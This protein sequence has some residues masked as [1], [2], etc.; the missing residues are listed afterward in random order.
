M[1][2]II[3]LIIA[4]AVA[5]ANMGSAAMAAGIIAEQPAGIIEDAPELLEVIDETGT[6]DT[7]QEILDTAA[8][9]AAPGDKIVVVGNVHDV[10]EHRT[11]SGC[12]YVVRDVGTVLNAD[13]DGR[14]DGYPEGHDYISYRGTGFEPGDRVITYT[15]MNPETD[16]CDD[17]LGRWDYLVG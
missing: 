8:G 3:S 6:L 4:A 14:V 10:P 11:G 12:V 5:A 15:I 2:D 13:G 1:K 17:D 7:P 16:W 9:Y